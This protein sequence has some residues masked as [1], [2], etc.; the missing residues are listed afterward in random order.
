MTAATPTPEGGSAPPT[1][2]GMRQGEGV[3]SKFHFVD[4][5]GSERASKTGNRGERFKGQPLPLLCPC[6]G[7]INFPLSES[8]YINT[9]LLSLGNVISAL[10]DPRRRVSHVPY[11]DSKITRLL[12]DSLGGNTSTVMVTCLSPA[13]ANFAENLNSLKYSKRVRCGEVAVSGLGQGYM[14]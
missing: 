11:R 10:S 13:S 6:S 2:D 3:S 4:L 5:A 1:K 9:G 8:I 14:D 12:K 7:F